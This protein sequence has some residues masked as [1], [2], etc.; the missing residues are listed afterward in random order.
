M[1]VSLA[2]FPQEDTPA[3]LR[4]AR[5]CHIIVFAQFRPKN[6]LKR[7]IR[8]MDLHHMMCTHLIIE[9]CGPIREILASGGS[10]AHLGRGCEVAKKLGEDGRV[11]IRNVRKAAMDKVPRA[12]AVCYTRPNRLVQ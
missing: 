6:Y 1:R 12:A 4:F 2:K 3:A 10:G 8:T 5:N 7:S 11:A 9:H